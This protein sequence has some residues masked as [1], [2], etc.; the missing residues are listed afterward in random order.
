MQARTYFLQQNLIL[1]PTIKAGWTLRHGLSC[2]TTCLWHLIKM[3]RP[4]ITRH[5]S[6]RLKECVESLPSL[7]QCDIDHVVAIVTTTAIAA[8]YPKKF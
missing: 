5:S 3:S 8:Q 6:T 7:A 2:W 1:A 4:Y